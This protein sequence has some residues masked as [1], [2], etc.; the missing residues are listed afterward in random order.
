[1]R[2]IANGC[3]S[4]FIG[5]F[6]LFGIAV[7]G[8]GL[9][10]AERSRRA[11][12]WPTVPG[13]I[14]RLELEESGDLDKGYRYEVKVRYKYSVA[15]KRYEGDRVA[16]GYTGSV[17]Q[18]AQQAVL[19]K[20]QKATMLEVRYD[21]EDPSSSC[22][23]YGVHHSIREAI[24]I[25]TFF[26]LISFIM[27]LAWRTFVLPPRDARLIDNLSVTSSASRPD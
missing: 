6:V 12:S 27:I 5:V 21:P 4:M 15:G 17:S 2:R 1:L 26:V 14:V 25:G 20:L 10:Q 11:G 16:I 7:I 22:L 9:W 19:A 8:F 3:F 18:A 24:A 23:S 13:K